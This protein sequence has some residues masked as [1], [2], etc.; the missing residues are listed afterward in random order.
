MFGKCRLTNR[1]FEIVEFEDEYNAK[2]SLQI[3]SRAIFEN[4]NGIVDDPLGWVWLGVDNASPKILKTKAAELGM[5][6]PPGEVSGW[7]PYSVP[8]DVLFT[9]RMHLSE[10]Q[11][12]GLIARLQT[13]L[14]T[15][16][17]KGDE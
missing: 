5:K 1:G 9:T 3:S 2:C 4:E 15:G 14:E 12:R 8:D 13:W 6:L 11:V 16:C 17:L 10:K 7:M